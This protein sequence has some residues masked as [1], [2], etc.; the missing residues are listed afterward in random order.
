MYWEFVPQYFN[1]YSSCHTILAYVGHFGVRCDIHHNTTV[2]AKIVSIRQGSVTT[3]YT[4]IF[5]NKLSTGLRNLLY[6]S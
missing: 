6:W 1:I 5:Y 2:Y 3:A 4:T